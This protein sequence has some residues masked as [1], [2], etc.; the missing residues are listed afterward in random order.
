MCSEKSVLTLFAAKGSISMIQK[1]SL[2]IYSFVL[3]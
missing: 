1:L 3:I 2:F